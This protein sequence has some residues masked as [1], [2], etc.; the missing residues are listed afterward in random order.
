MRLTP[1]R[2]DTRRTA[3]GVAGPTVEPADKVDRALGSN[4]SGTGSLGRLLCHSACLGEQPKASPRFAHSAQSA[5]VRTRDLL[6][7]KLL[8]VGPSIRLLTGKNFYRLRIAFTTTR[9][10]V[11]SRPKVL[12]DHAIEIVRGDGLFEDER[13]ARNDVF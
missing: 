3:K 11:G 6:T 9:R 2:W 10:S 1:M 7:D 13:V 12:D 5:A 4:P 8:G